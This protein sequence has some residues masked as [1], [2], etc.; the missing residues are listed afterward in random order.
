VSTVGGGREA[1]TRLREFRR[2]ALWLGL[3]LFGWALCVALSLVH[4]PSLGVDLPDGDKIGHFLAYGL[5]AA[6]AVWLFP[7]R[8]WQVAAALGLVA[9]GVAMEFAQ[10]ALT[11]DR[12]MDWRDAVADTIGI[13]VGARL[14]VRWPRALQALDGRFPP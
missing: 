6:W 11:S 2:P 7:S 10:G 4:P 14:G 9:L 5:L 3:W 12:M 1:S 8:R 13:A